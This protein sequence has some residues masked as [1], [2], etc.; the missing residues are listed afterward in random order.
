MCATCGGTCRSNDVHPHAQ[1]AAEAAEAAADQG[2]FWPM[3]DLLLTHQGELTIT[4][5][6]QYATELGLDIPK[7][8]DYVRRRAGASRIAEDVNSADLSNVSGTP[9]FFINGRRHF[10]AYDITELTAA[11]KTA[12]AATVRP[13]AGQSPAG[14]KTGPPA[15]P[16][17]GT[18]QQT[19]S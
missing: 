3:H 7:F 13:L 16:S 10:G 9:T 1:V 14:T 12:K 5:L 11:V 4:H 8:R 15:E 17:G 18:A 6:I 19:Q 2:A